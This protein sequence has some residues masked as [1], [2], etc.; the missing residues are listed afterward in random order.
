MSLSTMRSINWS[1]I[2]AALL[3]LSLSAASWAAP[4]EGCMPISAAKGVAVSGPR[5]LLI[6]AGERAW[7]LELAA[8]CPAAI[9]AR[10][11]RFISASADRQICTAR[12]D[13]IRV[14]QSQCE[15]AAVIE[16]APAVLRDAVVAMQALAAKAAEPICFDPSAI[17]RW[18]QLD[19]RTLLV[20]VRRQGQF[21]VHLANACSDLTDAN[22]ARFLP[23]VG[24]YFC[25][26]KTDLVVPIRAPTALGPT[27]RLLQSRLERQGCPVLKIESYVPDP[28]R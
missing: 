3:G 23:S 26:S 28:K 4:L 6:D 18:R 20:D 7:V 13:S 22:D 10:K 1:V 8:D 5:E 15:V 27:P 9:G 21:I 16:L 25:G 17:R 19:R 2:A 24:R 11:I 12:A 14:E